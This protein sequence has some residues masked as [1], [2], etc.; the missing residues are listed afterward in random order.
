MDLNPTLLGQL[1]L[2][3]V[4][5]STLIIGILA[6]RKTDSPILTTAIGF[7]LSF[8]PLCSL[9]FIAVLALKS[10]EAK[11]AKQA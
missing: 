9:I 4:V 2:G 10:N 3:W 5:L 7:M 6:Y 1:L 11:Q 8:V